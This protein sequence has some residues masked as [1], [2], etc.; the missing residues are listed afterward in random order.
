M[1]DSFRFRS[2]FAGLP[3]EVPAG[4]AHRLFGP[5]MDPKRDPKRTEA[6]PRDQSSNGKLDFWG[7]SK[8]VFVDVLDRRPPS[9]VNSG[10]N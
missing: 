3:P 7:S 10:V 5:K 9:V 6:E 4:V 2:R 8:F 1:D